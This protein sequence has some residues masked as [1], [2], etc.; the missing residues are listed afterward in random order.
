MIYSCMCVYSI[1][2]SCLFTA[3]EGHSAIHEISTMKSVLLVYYYITIIYIP[4]YHNLSLTIICE[5][6]C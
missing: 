6:I 3:A 5:N 4:F 2:P 1:K